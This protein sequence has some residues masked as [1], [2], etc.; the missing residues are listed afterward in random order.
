MMKAING[1]AAAKMLLRDQ[2]QSQ[3]DL[4]TT[5]A[6]AT[7]STEVA[8]SVGEGTTVVEVNVKFEEWQQA[9]SKLTDL[10]GNF[11]SDEDVLERQ[12]QEVMKT[13]KVYVETKNLLT[14]VQL[15]QLRP[16]TALNAEGDAAEFDIIVHQLCSMH[17]ARNSHLTSDLA[18][19]LATKAAV[20]PTQAAL[21]YYQGQLYDHFPKS[22]VDDFFSRAMEWSTVAMLALG[23]K[24]N[25]GETNQ[26]SSEVLHHADNFLRTLPIA[27]G[28][29]QY[30][31][32][33]SGKQLEHY[34]EG[35]IMQSKGR[36]VMKHV[37]EK[38][39]SQGLFLSMSYS[40]SIIN[41]NGS[42]IN[43]KVSRKDGS[44]V[45]YNVTLDHSKVHTTG[46]AQCACGYTIALGLPC[47]HCAFVLLHLRDIFDEFNAKIRESTAKLSLNSLPYFSY[48]MPKFYHENWH[49]N[50]YVAQYSQEVYVPECDL[51]R[52]KQFQLFPPNQ[53]L[54]VGRQK[55]NR[56]K[57]SNEFQKS[58]EQKNKAQ[59][60]VKES[61]HMAKA[62][63][64]MVRILQ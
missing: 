27:E 8:V 11:S 18:K 29:I 4:S 5:E 50:T 44:G 31:T 23:M 12:Q 63:T 56:I 28:M 19:K 3:S 36:L 45:S 59:E 54:P 26:N 6:I 58:L 48:H 64:T 15:Q 39:K 38:T 16:G 61:Q 9:H 49:V 10:A 62:P 17:G 33:K 41:M 51:S 34:T 46:S 47:Y 22:Q 1:A 30:Y 7:T 42:V 60:T 40:A 14:K 32:K 43:F 13:W 2:Q 35:K 52:D 24:T 21:D 53:K 55:S 57:N 37:T 25:L 20:A